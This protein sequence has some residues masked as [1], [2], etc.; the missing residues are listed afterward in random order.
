MT[1]PS[2]SLNRAFFW[3]LASPILFIPWIWTQFF[4]SAI[5]W[6]LIALFAVWN[7]N[8]TL[9]YAPIWLL[10]AF[11]LIVPFQESQEP[12]INV[13][14][15]ITDNI[16]DFVNDSLFPI[17]ED[18][19]Y[20]IQPG[21][22]A[23]NFLWD[24]G[25]TIFR[26][27][28]YNPLKLG[29]T[30]FVHGQNPLGF[31]LTVPFAATAFPLTTEI[32]TSS[33]PNWVVG[34][35]G[36]GLT[37]SDISY[38][39]QNGTQEL[40]PLLDGS[41]S[42]D[43]SDPFAAAL[44][45]WIR[46]H[47]P[48]SVNPETDGI[49]L[50]IPSMIL[51][52]WTNP[53]V[54]DTSRRAIS[55]QLLRKV[56]DRTLGLEG[57]SWWEPKDEKEALE[58]AAPDSATIWRRVFEVPEQVTGM[59]NMGVVRLDTLPDLV[60]EYGEERARDIHIPPGSIAFRYLADTKGT[61]NL[62]FPL[63]QEIA[64]LFATIFDA[65]V[66]VLVEIWKIALRVAKF[67]FGH[68]ETF[69]TDAINF[70]ANVFNEIWAEFL[71]L[72]CMK[73]DSIE[74][75]A[76][77]VLDCICGPLTQAVKNLGGNIEQW[78]NYKRPSSISGLPQAILG[79]IGLGCID[80]S[81]LVTAPDQFAAQLLGDCMN[82][83]DL[84]VCCV[85]FPTKCFINTLMVIT[86][87]ESYCGGSV[88]VSPPE[89]GFS[90][91]NGNDALKCVIMWIMR[92]VVGIFNYSKKGVVSDCN[93]KN[94]PNFLTLSK[95]FVTCIALSIINVNA[96]FDQIKPILKKI[97]GLGGGG[98]LSD[99]FGRGLIP[100][101][102][103]SSK[104]FSMWT[105][106][107]TYDRS[108]KYS[109]DAPWMKDGAG[110]RGRSGV[111][112]P[113]DWVERLRLNRGNTIF[114]REESTNTVGD[115]KKKDEIIDYY[116]YY[117]RLN[118]NKTITTTATT[119][120]PK[121][122]WI[123]DINAT[124]EEYGENAI[125]ML[126]RLEDE[127]RDRRIQAFYHNMDPT[128][129]EIDA[130]LEREQAVL[131]TYGSLPLAQQFSR[132]MDPKSR[133]RHRAALQA[134]VDQR[135]YSN[136][137]IRAA[138]GRFLEI[139][140][141][142]TD[143][144]E[145]RIYGSDPFVM[146]PDDADPKEDPRVERV[147]E[148]RDTTQDHANAY[149][150]YQQAVQDSPYYAGLY[151]MLFQL[152]D[153]SMIG[154]DN[155][156]V[157]NTWEA[158]AAHADN[159]LFHMGRMMAAS[160]QL[161]YTYGVFADHVWWEPDT[162]SFHFPSYRHMEQLAMQTHLPAYMDDMRA[163]VVGMFQT[164]A[165]DEH[166]EL[167]ARSV[168]YTDDY[169]EHGPTAQQYHG[170]PAQSYSLMVQVEVTLR[171]VV[172]RLL[173][174]RHIDP[175]L[176]ELSTRS[177]LHARYC[178]RMRYR[179]AAIKDASDRAHV[180]LEEQIQAWRSR[181]AGTVTVNKFDNRT[182]EIKREVVNRPL[183]DLDPVAH[184]DAGNRTLVPGERVRFADGK[185]GVFLGSM[186]SA[187]PLSPTRSAVGG[188]G[189]RTT[190]IGMTTRAIQILAV[191]K[192]VLSVVM[193][194]VSNWQL[195]ATGFMTVVVSPWGRVFWE[196]WL[197]FLY[198][199]II[200]P[201]YTDGLRALFGSIFQILE[202]VFD[203]AILNETIWFFLMNELFRYVLCFSW[204]ALII[205]VLF[206]IYVVAGFLSW[207]IL[208]IP[209]AI[210]FV[211]VGLI[212][213]TFPYCPP[214]QVLRNNKMTQML[215]TYFNDIVECF[216]PTDF[217]KIKI[218]KDAYNGVCSVKTDCPGNAPCICENKGG[219]YSSAFA[220]F[221][222][223]TACGTSAA[224]TGQCLCWPK[225]DC[226]FLFPRVG[227]NRLFDV[228]CSATYS[229]RINKITWYDT[230]DFV[231]I[232]KNAYL[233][234]WISLRYVTRTLTLAPA[235]NPFLFMILITFGFLLLFYA[236]FYV[237]VI[238]IVL[239]MS[240]QYALPLWS[241]LTMDYIIPGLTNL[242]NHTVFPLSNLASWLLTFLRFPNH[243]SG[244]PLGSAGDGESV[245]WF[246]NLATMF[247]G[248]AV[249]YWF[250]AI[251]LS[252]LWYGFGPIIWFVFNN[253]AAPFRVALA[254]FWLYYQ[255][256]RLSRHFAKAKGLIRRAMPTWARQGAE[257]AGSNVWRFTSA[258]ASQLMP[259]APQTPL[260]QWISKFYPDPTQV[261]AQPQAPIVMDGRERA[262]G[263]G[264]LEYETHPNPIDVRS[265]PPPQRPNQPRRRRRQVP[266]L[267]RPK[268]V[269]P[270]V[271]TTLPS[272]QAPTYS[273]ESPL[274]P[275]QAQ[276]EEQKTTDVRADDHEKQV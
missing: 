76:I 218:G 268:R 32:D 251:I 194:L 55:E 174:P 86:N 50:V 204:V 41:R 126:I 232:F 155:L 112:T 48:Q 164:E 210:I 223:N 119:E 74:V 187:S 206:P 110:G 20:I 66:T 35:Y 85:I 111:L 98:F 186:G 201:L 125:T 239:T 182:G 128:D 36:R 252:L 272:T 177:P 238:V 6:A 107:Q 46:R 104:S 168:A 11:F 8:G 245:C 212:A 227:T 240:F 172:T 176:E 120:T 10:G 7:W 77:S 262:Y 109:R 79:C 191:A 144:A 134:R 254:P 24:G 25:M 130:M 34:P 266:I 203:F 153:P 22:W 276:T 114:E 189:G 217:L 115:K 39:S 180:E 37:R 38:S 143:F 88:D 12:V 21:C 100:E 59:E 49:R 80:V 15:F 137:Y 60:A 87:C 216:G 124:R 190:G 231:L 101:D 40:H 133:S 219:Q 2:T 221:T 31:F 150:F 170:G 45:R 156:D 90:N 257:T 162:F 242:R 234:F 81:L 274:P 247:G 132:A 151:K 29:M 149:A 241:N 157:D 211:P 249:A 236:N 16:D 250:W 44:F 69:F 73:F 256:S 260:N 215:Y 82:L 263:G 84:A 67:L 230:S 138:T 258:A 75:F 165:I 142:M 52:A 271:P 273:P 28:I 224:P 117:D 135:V 51:D 65:V 23:Y 163:A 244:S 4:A 214:E 63:L 145:F 237:G 207:G 160:R 99:I 198:L 185:T 43:P 54:S 122:T 139:V 123:S 102:E 147:P 226:Q 159:P 70:I 173:S 91:N 83:P 116:A 129:T 228:D 209:L 267:N 96:F 154:R 197:Q 26:I 106:D 264:T 255:R 184:P 146:P 30:M 235:L 229:Y 188:W 78:F 253:V 13:L 195:I 56:M 64:A 17:I 166:E 33:S 47:D 179:S 118:A 72:P 259:E 92:V 175:M 202:L 141:D 161:L 192:E 261:M 193:F 57:R 220:A 265:R 205:L 275:P 18:I 113:M 181:R 269:R 71:G 246:F 89:C 213:I 127:A 178:E 27:A 222:D 152:G 108:V 196:S 97:L 200:K 5:S 208:N 62:E 233:N 158:M 58:E 9:Y 93:I 3:R 183:I 53:D 94:C 243:S 1:R 167:V 14:E 169:Y 19:F 270:L 248:A 131:Q 61:R 225:L 103:Q 199:R 140:R 105:P 136:P 68:L 42:I 121:S 171:T 148:F 95:K